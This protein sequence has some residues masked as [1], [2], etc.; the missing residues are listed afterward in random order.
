[1]PYTKKNRNLYG[2]SQRQHNLNKAL[3]QARQQHELRERQ[4][5]AASAPA[6]NYVQVPINVPSYTNPSRGQ[7][8]IDVSLQTTIIFKVKIKIKI[9]IKLL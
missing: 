1:M 7:R 5:A 2:G 4:R 3:R 9:K 6:N 8:I